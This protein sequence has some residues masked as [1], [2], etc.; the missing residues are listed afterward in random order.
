MVR[1]RSSLAALPFIAA[2]Y[3]GAGGAGGDDGGDGASSDAGSGSDAGDTGVAAVCGEPGAVIPG[4]APLRRMTRFEYNNTVFDL[5]GDDTLPGNAFPSE[6]IGNG[7]GN[8]ADAQAVSSLLAE[9]YLG[10]AEDI[11]ARATETP[12]KLG[13]LSSCA[14]EIT[15]S[16]DRATE[17]ACARTLI[18]ELLP[19]AFRRPVDD[20]EIA[21]LVALQQAI[22]EQA[23]FPLSIA[24]TIEAILQSPDFLYRVESGEDDGN[25]HRRP[26]GHEMATRL[27]YFF[28]GTM[29]DADLFA[30]AEAGELVDAEGVH[31]QAERL[32]DD[33]RSH[34]VVRHFFDNLL[35]IGSLSQLERDDVRYPKYTAQ[36]GAYMR[37]E[38]QTFL[39]HEIFEGPGTWPDAL[40]AE[41]TF[42]NAALAEYYGIAGVE[43]DA[44]QKVDIDTTQRLGLLTQ[45]GVVAG[46]IH[47]NETNP[48][49]RG[50]FVTQKLMCN[51]IPLPTGDVAAEVVPPDPDSGATARERYSQHSEDPV[52]AGCHRFMDPIGLALENYDAV[53]LW[54]DTENGV[55]IDASGAVPGTEGTVDG[56]VALARKIAEAPETQACFARHWSNFAYGRTLD[57]EDEADT[58]VSDGITAVF[59]ESGYDIRE[60]LLA[61]TQTDAFLYLPTE[62]E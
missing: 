55:A 54:R 43:G 30:A 36:I 15:T 53:G 62:Q 7:F 42:V 46:T 3:T 2:C 29:P 51:T 31:A 22:R 39:E 56:P 1:A 21:E 38:T 49:V 47:S 10:V 27:S 58:C 61:L 8:D 13:A 33:P 19:R 45:A 11:A 12:A 16:T 23:E 34:H 37:E 18:A 9:Q 41:Y 20:A 4:R 32:L 28:W 50:S 40:T 14:G 24:T 26:T 35:P 25:G 60:L 44:F 17:D 59:T 52:C 48:V 6:E 57:R 5:L